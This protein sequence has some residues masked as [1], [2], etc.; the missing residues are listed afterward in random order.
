MDGWMVI[1]GTFAHVCLPEYRISAFL[2]LPLHTSHV[3][4]GLG[5]ALDRLSAVDIENWAFSSWQQFG[6]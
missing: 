1:Q 5:Q 2:A 4:L 6:R 3:D